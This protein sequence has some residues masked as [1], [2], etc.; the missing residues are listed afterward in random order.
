MNTHN[1]AYRWEDFQT[2]NINATIQKHEQWL[3]DTFNNNSRRIADQID[4]TL[5]PFQ[6]NVDAFFLV[7][8]AIHIHGNSSIVLILVKFA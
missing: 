5:L 3:V 8:M 7:V 2:D 1:T 4:H 6:E